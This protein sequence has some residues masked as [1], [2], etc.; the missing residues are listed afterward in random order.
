MAAKNPWVERWPV[1]GTEDTWTVSR[2]EDGSWGCSCPKWIFQKVP[3]GSRREDCHHIRQIRA[4][5]PEVDAAEVLSALAGGD[6]VK[7]YQL[8]SE[9]YR[10]SGF[11]LVGHVSDPMED[12]QKQHYDELRH[13][14]DMA[15][16]LIAGKAVH[17]RSDRNCNEIWVKQL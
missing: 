13:R 11:I 14:Q 6:P 16:V 17:H 7:R 5:T 12:Y 15:V 8:L 4:R 2:R 3:E 10:R 1:E 9:A